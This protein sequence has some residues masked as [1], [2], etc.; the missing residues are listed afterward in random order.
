LHF[1]TSLRQR[2]IGIEPA[3]RRIRECDHSIRFSSLSIIIIA[4]S[5]FT[6]PYCSIL[7]PH[8]RTLPARMG[9]SQDLVLRHSYIPTAWYDLATFLP[10]FLFEQSPS[11]ATCSSNSQRFCNKYPHFS[12]LSIS[13][14]WSTDCRAF[15]PRL[16]P[17]RH[18]NQLT[19]NLTERTA[20]G[21]R[22]GGPTV[23]A[24]L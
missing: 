24:Q 7:P 9:Q 12:Y 11:L 1:T 8:Q 2:K 16:S 22:E 13:D 14:G 15:G 3:P 6:S 21:M 17:R 4:R 18:T 5:S 20:R 19:P 10:K 23:F